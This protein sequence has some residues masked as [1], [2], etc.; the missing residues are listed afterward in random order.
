MFRLSP[1]AA[2]IGTTP[3]RVV[4]GGLE[5]SASSRWSRFLR[6]SVLGCFG[7]ALAIVVWGYNYR[8]SLYHPHRDTA[9]RTLAAKL[10]VD[11]RQAAV[12][13]VA[14]LGARTQQ[15]ASSDAPDLSPLHPFD[16]TCVCALV[17]VPTRIRRTRCAKSLLP[18][19][20]P[21]S[22]SFSA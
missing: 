21:P 6:P 20:S 3:E 7:L 5:E 13:V 9:S 15:H 11:Q 16:L 2:V 14:H 19:R 22:S 1:K 18:P 12:E 8:L 17:A 10:W 4:T